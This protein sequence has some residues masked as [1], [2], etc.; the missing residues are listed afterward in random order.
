M[1]LP[2]TQPKWWEQWFQRQG[3]WSALCANRNPAQ[4]PCMDKDGCRFFRA[5][6]DPSYHVTEFVFSLAR[7]DS[8]TLAVRKLHPT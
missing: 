3:W 5:F 6:M 2:V 4:W 1:K 7:M 8:G